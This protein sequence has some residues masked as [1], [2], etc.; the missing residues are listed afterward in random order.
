MFPVMNEPLIEH[1]IE[2]L[3]QKGLKDII[4]TFSKES[5]TG[6]LESIRER[7]RDKIN[8]RLYRE[9][10]PRGTAGILADVAEFLENEPFLVINSSL[11]MEDVDLEG[12]DNFHES[13][14]SAVTVGMKRCAEEISDMY[15]I[16]VSTDGAIEEVIV[17]HPST[18][19]KIPWIFSGIYLF[20][21]A[22][23]NFIDPK[24]YLD[25]KEQ[26]IPALRNASLPVYA[27]E[28]EGY[29]KDI[30]SMKDY[31]SLHRDLFAM[32]SS[33]VY[34][35]D[36]REIADE[37]WVGKDT[38]ISPGSYLM[39]PIVLGNGCYIANHAQLIGPAVIGDGCK[40]GEGAVVRESIFWSYATLE[41][42][43]RS[44]YCI[45]GEGLNIREGK[46]LRN[47]VVVDELS[48]GDMNLI[49]QD[50]RITGVVGNYLSQILIDSINKWILSFIKWAMDISIAFASL[51]LLAP[52]F[53]LIALAIKIDSPGPILFIQKRCG[54]HGEFFKMFKFRTMVASAEKIHV[55]LLAKKDTD[56][57][58]FK[59][60]NDPRVTRIGRILRKGSLD[61]L[62]QLINVI[63]GEMSIVGPRPLIT[64]EMKFNLSWRDVRLRVKPGI[65][66]L[67][68]V[69]GRSEAPFHDWIRY[70]T[71]YVKNQ[72]V[73]LDIKILFKTLK[74]VFKKVGA[75]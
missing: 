75:Y 44:E 6:A 58:M 53:V 65:T 8:I 56:G 60:V 40:I 46:R 11:Y 68:Q 26:L 55:E 3:Y 22:I 74:V 63:R 4:I 29:C 42:R 15:A 18:N 43:V 72:S 14:R 49:P 45:V 37:V 21:P 9:S 48:I 12:M 25:I 51:V 35:K 31:F 73:W 64:E 61:E 17:I 39:G 70:D 71:E 38:E 57:P 66:G 2:F 32:K 62:P 28:I 5:A 1:N 36:K 67:W 41:K 13:K 59:M 54:R 47:L 33:A 34:F 16:R 19:R 52:V 69:Q 7:N 27:S 24:K 23:F 50:Y 30:C 10:V 20:T